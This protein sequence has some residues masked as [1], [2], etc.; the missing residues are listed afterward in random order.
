MV[1]SATSTAPDTVRFVRDPLG[2]DPDT[3]WVAMELRNILDERETAI[4]AVLDLARAPRLRLAAGRSL[5]QTLPRIDAQS[6]ADFEWPLLPLPGPSTEAQHITIRY[7][8]IEQG[9]WKECMTSII[10]EEWPPVKTTHCVVSGHDSLHAD[11]AYE[12]II[13]EPFEI[14]YTATNTGTVVLRNCSATITLPPEFELVSDSATL[15]FGELRPGDSNTRW[16]TLKTTPALADF[17]A[18]PVNF[19]WYSDEQGSTTGCDHTVHVLPDAPTGIVFTPLHLHFEAKQDDPLPAAQYIQLWTGG[20][21]SMPWT[22]QGGQW[23]LNADPVSG[24]HAARIA[25][26]PNSTALPF[27]LH[28]TK[29]SIAGQAPNLPKDVAVTYEITGLLDVGRR[30][31][32][33]LYGMGPVWP[34]PVP[35]NGEAR[36]SINVSRWRLCAH[37]ALRRAGQRGGCGERGSDARGGSRVAHRTGGVAFEARDVFHSNDRCGGA[38]NASGGGAVETPGRASVRV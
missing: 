13:P 15:S 4:E 20:G 16:W 17:G 25:V 18:Y 3:A 11:Q 14:S 28:A 36:I 29:L 21:L 35:L 27:G 23:W 37:R 9:D 32:A 5:Q 30:A 7:R 31:A 38:G 22:A 12:R 6:N 24:D 2:Y 8:S 1:C 19:T 34:Q 33:R 26:Q 10:I